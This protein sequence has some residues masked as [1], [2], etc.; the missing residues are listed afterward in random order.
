MDSGL[1]LLS[2]IMLR[3][4]INLLVLNCPIYRIDTT[5]L[6]MKGGVRI[7]IITVLWHNNTSLW[8]TH[9]S[10]ADKY[11]NSLQIGKLRG[12]EILMGGEK[13]HSREL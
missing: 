13:S 7:T 4:L 1:A 9:N 11:E 12:E 3:K 10:R 6:C 8:S 2:S 5:I